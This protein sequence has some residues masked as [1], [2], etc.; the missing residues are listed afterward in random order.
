MAQIRIVDADGHIFEDNAEIGKR[1]PKVFRDWKYA[2]GLFTGQPW[3]PP[4]GHLHTP[5]GKNPEGAFGGGEHVGVEHWLEFIDKTGI[6]SAVLF[7]SGGL[8]YGHITSADYAISVTRAYNDWLA[9]EYVER[10]SVF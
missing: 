2:H 9:E 4:L 10:S 5:T 6:E 3:F 7:P 1:M 8:T